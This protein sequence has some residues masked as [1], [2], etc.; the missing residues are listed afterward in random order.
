MALQPIGGGGYDY[1]SN[2]EP[3]DPDYGE[4]WLDTSINPPTVKVY[5]DLGS[6]G[7]WTATDT[8]DA[9][10]GISEELQNG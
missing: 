2:T 5:A 6:G 8:A 10:S 1:V 9:V 4:M 3:T 7:Q